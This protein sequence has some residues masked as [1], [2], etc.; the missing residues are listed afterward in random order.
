MYIAAMFALH[1][2]RC[3]SYPSQK[4]G[5]ATANHKH[6]Y[7]LAKKYACVSESIKSCWKKSCFMHKLHILQKKFQQFSARKVSCGKKS[8]SGKKIN[9]SIQLHAI[10]LSNY[11]M[12]C[13]KMKGQ[14]MP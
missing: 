3:I 6:K 7:I 8:S 5:L 4:S 10:I 2:V 9:I 1:L 11:L 13:P 12:P 14:G